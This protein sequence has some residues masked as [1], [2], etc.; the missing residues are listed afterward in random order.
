[1]SK[2]S[3]STQE[4][5]APPPLDTAALHRRL[6]EVEAQLQRQS[7]MQEAF[8]YG[9]SHD[10]RAPL[11]AIMTFADLLAQ[12]AE[13]GLDALGRD[14]LRRIRAA[15][16]RMDRL[17]DALHDLSLACRATLQPR[18]VDISLLADWVATEI[19]DRDRQRRARI[20]VA[21]RLTAWGDERLLK[22]MLSQ[23][24]DNAWRFTAAADDVRIQVEGEQVGQ[25]T[26]L[27]VRDHGIGFDMRY[28]D[29]LF[30]IFGRLHGDDE[31]AGAGIGLAIAQCV[32]QRHGGRIRADSAPG[33]GSVFHIELPARPD[34]APDER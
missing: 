13:G 31:G 19:R 32:A 1:M 2:H 5:G 6:N 10:L 18:L 11:R 24:I 28:A 27:R 4:P 25:Q 12:R 30:E 15:A 33:Q 14:H 21:P 8:A 9:V 34:G 29:K 16:M 20:E 7:R 17:L 22:L 23:L 3:Q 26:H